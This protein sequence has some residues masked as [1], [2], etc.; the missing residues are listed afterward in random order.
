MNNVL[1]A[2]IA[3]LVA[4]LCWGTS[5]WLA[6]RGAKKLS[7]IAMNFGTQISSFTLAIVIWLV[8]QPQLPAGSQLLRIIVASTL[9]TSAFL[10]FI[11]ALSSG[12]VGIIAPIGN[13]YPLIT[14]L[15]A[16]LIGN[17]HRPAAVR[18]LCLYLDW[19][20]SVGL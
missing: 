19:S 10:V 7:P 6:A 17:H 1:V 9:I 20:R 14:I 5:D 18:G 8:W 2:T 13:S 15:L 4:A 11:K 12:A 3:G 16:V